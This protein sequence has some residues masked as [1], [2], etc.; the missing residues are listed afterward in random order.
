LRDI[1]HITGTFGHVL[2]AEYLQDKYRQG[3]HQEWVAEGGVLLRQDSFTPSKRDKGRA[4]YHRSSLCIWLKQ[5]PMEVEVQIGVN[6]PLQYQ[7]RKYRIAGEWRTDFPLEA[8]MGLTFNQP[9]PNSLCQYQVYRGTTEAKLYLAE[10][11][12]E[13]EEQ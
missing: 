9:S 2:P 4:S 3:S 5:T 10:A 8:P 12:E 1:S 7:S 6:I 13:Q 11:I